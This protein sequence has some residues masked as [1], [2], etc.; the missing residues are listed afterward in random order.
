[1]SFKTYIYSHRLIAK[2]FIATLARILPAAVSR[3][4]LALAERVAF[5]VTPQYQG[6]TLPPIFGYWSS[7]FL[8][9]DAR[10]LGADSPETFYLKHV[11]EAAGDGSKTV[12]VMSVGTGA[13]AMETQLAVQL[14]KAGVNA[15]IHCLDFNPGLM[16]RA[17]AV[18]R[19]NDVNGFMSFETQDCNRPFERSLQ[20]VII[21][22]QFFHHVTE[23]EIFCQSLGQSL[24]ADGVLLSSDIV[25]RNGHLLWPDVEVEVKKAWAALPLSKRYDRHFSA[26]QTHYIPVNHAAYSNEGVRAED[27]VDSLLH[28]FDFELFFTFGGAIMPFIERRIGFNF[29]PEEEADRNVIDALGEAD[30][31]SLAAGRYPASNMIASLRH[32]GHVIQ[33]VHEPVTP[34]QHVAMTRRQRAKI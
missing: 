4:L 18:A 33:A 12:Q 30:E 6:D 14:K 22:N 27:V 23:L 16:R 3:Q 34:G 7:R 17:E 24:A 10:R 9:P 25:G 11:I 32:K 28:T 20:D 2:K 31:K 13:C 8:T 21:V 29:D 19:D 15:H 1:M 5:N 26:R